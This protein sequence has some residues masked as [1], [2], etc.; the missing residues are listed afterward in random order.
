MPRLDVWLVDTGHFSSRQLAK[1]A[2]KEGNVTVDGKTCKP[3]ANVTGKENIKILT[4]AANMPIGYLK[5]EKLDKLM[6]ENLVEDPCLALDIG[7]SAGGF[8]LYL[9]HKGARAIGIEVSDRFSERLQDIAETY[10]EISVVFADA[11]SIEPSSILSEGE[12]DLL[13]IDVTTDKD[14]TLNL[15]S[16]FS[17]LLRNGGKLLAAFKL[18]N[19]PTIVLQVIESIKKMGFKQIKTFHLDDSRQEVHITASFM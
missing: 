2:I 6:D 5:L 19:E 3:S 7:S 16:R 13:L 18:E 17:F 12:L 10:P 9:Q 11:F 15:I 4:D 1:R 8:L 14:G